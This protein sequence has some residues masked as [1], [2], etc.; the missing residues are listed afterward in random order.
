VLI[1]RGG[2]AFSR[3]NFIQPN[4]EHITI[5]PGLT[6]W[7]ILRESPNQV[8]AAS[9]CLSGILALVVD[10]NSCAME[11][12]TVSGTKW[13]ADFS[14]YSELEIFGCLTICSVFQH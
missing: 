10:L 1:S 12:R 9:A 6:S 5:F 2:S 13:N 3:E 7:A 4:N 11:T 8:S 14:K